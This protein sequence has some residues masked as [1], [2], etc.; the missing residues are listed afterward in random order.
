MSVIKIRN[1]R[2]VRRG[3]KATISQATPREALRVGAGDVANF[4][5]SLTVGNTAQQLIRA[6]RRRDRFTV[7]SI[8]NRPCTIRFFRTRFFNCVRICCFYGNNN[9]IRI[10]FE[11]CVRRVFFPFKKKK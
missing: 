2:M 11:I 8:L 9:Q 3:R 5:Q 10:C 6:I 1:V 4:F 7:R